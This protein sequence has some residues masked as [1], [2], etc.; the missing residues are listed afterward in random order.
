[1]TKNVEDKMSEWISVKDR[2][3]VN[4]EDAL[5]AYH[6]ENGSYVL[7]GFCHDG[8]WYTERYGG[9]ELDCVTHWMKFPLPPQPEVLVGM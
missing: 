2:L 4:Y 5:V 3:P 1:V 9:I 8:D 6:D 7:P